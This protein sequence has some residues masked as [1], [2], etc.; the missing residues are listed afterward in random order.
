MWAKKEEHLI[1]NDTFFNNKKI[2][3]GFSRFNWRLM[4]SLLIAKFFAKAE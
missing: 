4:F 1:L 2:R 3:K